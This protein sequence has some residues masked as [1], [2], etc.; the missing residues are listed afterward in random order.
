MYMETS[1][2]TLC[3]NDISASLINDL[4]MGLESPSVVF[5][6]Y[7]YSPEQSEKMLK[8]KYFITALQAAQ[9]EWQAAKN[10]AERVRLKS[11]IALEELLVPMFTMANDPD[12][13]PAIRVE[14]AKFYRQTAGMDKQEVTGSGSGFSLTLNLGGATSEKIVIEQ[15]ARVEGS[16]GDQN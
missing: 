7:G 11:L 5:S 16:N 4:A 3:Q 13:S 6:R 10:S 9:T 14:I 2:D 8:S 15:P 12:I 1:R